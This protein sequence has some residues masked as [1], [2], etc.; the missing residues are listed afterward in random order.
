MEIKIDCGCGTRFKFDVEP[1]HGCMPVRVQCPSCGNDA[2]TDANQIIARKLP[3]GRPSAAPAP[4]PEPAQTTMAVGIS[5]TQTATSATPSLR[6]ASV[7]AADYATGP[8]AVPASLLDRTTFF[9]KERVAIVKLTD[10]YDILDPAT[11]QQIGI[12]RE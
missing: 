7:P 8:A 6:I 2:T 12:A 4:R 5:P 1:T 11:G 10:T 9:I 3:D